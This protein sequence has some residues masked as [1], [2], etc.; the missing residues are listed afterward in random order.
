M[1]KVVSNNNS[2]NKKLLATPGLFI[3]C[4]LPISPFRCW[5]SFDYFAVKQAVSAVVDKFACCKALLPAQVALLLSACR[6]L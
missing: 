6:V 1:S 4:Q 3:N 2:C 5:F